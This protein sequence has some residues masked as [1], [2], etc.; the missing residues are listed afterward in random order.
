MIFCA[1]Q[2]FKLLRQIKGNSIEVVIFLKLVGLSGTAIVI[3]R[4]GRQ[5]PSYAFG[6]GK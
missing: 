3:A 1:E 4:P 2:N 5:N 6:G